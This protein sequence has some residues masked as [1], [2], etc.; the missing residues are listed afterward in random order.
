GEGGQI[1]DVGKGLIARRVKLQRQDCRQAAEYVEVVP[2]DHRPHGGRHK[3][4]PDTVIGRDTASRDCRATHA[5]PPEPGGLCQAPWPSLSSFPGTLSRTL[6]TTFVAR[7]S[8]PNKE[9][10]DS[11]R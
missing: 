5:F 11:W 10:Q 1:S 3:H 6:L 7:G 4:P 2:L 8:P 9:R